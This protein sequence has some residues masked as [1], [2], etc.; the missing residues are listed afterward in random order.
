MPPKS[1]IRK[2]KTVNVDEFNDFIANVGEKLASNFNTLEELKVRK[3]IISMFLADITQSEI[4]NIIETLKT[5][6]SLDTYGL[7]L[8]H[9]YLTKISPVLLPVLLPV[10]KKFF[11]K[12]LDRQVFPGS[13]KIA[14]IKPLSKEGN[15]PDSS[16]Y[17]SISLLPVVGKIFER[18]ISNRLNQ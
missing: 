14:K 12:C 1:T 5:K 3:Q 9:F 13:F 17:R 10:L 11:Q 2:K 6:L 18:L 4:S 7:N 8:N 15:D 16:N